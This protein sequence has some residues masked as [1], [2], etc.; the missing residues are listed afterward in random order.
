MLMAAQ[1]WA[2]GLPGVRRCVRDRSS[3]PVNQVV[4]SAIHVQMAKAT[5]DAMKVKGAKRE[6]RNLLTERSGGMGRF[7]HDAGRLLP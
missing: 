6:R 4:P 3:S 2:A 5:V 7:C 1:T